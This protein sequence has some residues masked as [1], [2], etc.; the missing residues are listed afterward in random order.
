ME[1]TSKFLKAC[2]DLGMLSNQLFDVSDLH[3]RRNL[4]RVLN[5]LLTL[6]MLERG[7]Q[8]KQTKVQKEHGAA[9]D[10]NKPSYLQRRVNKVESSVTDINYVPTSK[11]LELG[12][13]PVAGAAKIESMGTV[14]E[15]YEAEDDDELTVFK[16]DVVEIRLANGGWAFTGPNENWVVVQKG[17]ESGMIPKH[18]F[19]AG[20]TENAY[21][22]GGKGQVNNL[23]DQELMAK[24]V[25]K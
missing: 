2:R 5:S 14:I 6:R 1:N 3:E 13:G 8:F 10:A 7:A 18:V 16:G 4:K 20:I 21:L 19:E 9:G 25:A 17:T 23:L 12:L 24:K 11:K 15:D 22:G